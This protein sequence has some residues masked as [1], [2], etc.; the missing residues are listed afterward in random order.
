METVVLSSDIARLVLDYLKSQNLKRATHTFC[1]TSPY[2]KQEFSAFKH[3]LQT[4]SFFPELEEIICEYVKISRKVDLELPKL[5]N[6]VRFEFQ[7]LK[8]SEKVAVLLERTAD[9]HQEIASVKNASSN[10]QTSAGS[11]KQT[12]NS[13]NS[14]KEN[15]G[16][17]KKRKRPHDLN[18]SHNNDISGDTKTKDSP[19]YRT[20]HWSKKRRILEPYCFLSAKALQRHRLRYNICLSPCAMGRRVDLKSHDDRD[21]GDDDDE[22]DEDED[23]EWSNSCSEITTETEAGDTEDTECDPA[24][25]NGKELFN[26]EKPSKESTPRNKTQEE[27][28]RTPILPEISQAILDNPEFQ[29]KLVENINQALNSSATKLPPSN[30]DVKATEDPASQITNNQTTSTQDQSAISSTQLLD[31]MIKN[32]LEA[33][34]KDPSFD[35][36]IHDVLEASNKPIVQSAA[37]QCNIGAPTADACVSA[38]VGD[39]N[40]PLYTSTEPPPLVPTRP[41]PAMIDQTLTEQHQLPQAVN[42]SPIDIPPRTPLII[43]NAV[44]AAN[45]SNMTTT[46][47]S[48]AQDPPSLTANNSFGSLIDPNFSISKLIVLNSNDSAQK[49]HPEVSIGNITAENIINQLTTSS[50]GVTENVSGSGVVTD[51][52]GDDQVFFDSSTGQLTFPL[53]LTNDGLLANLPFLINNEVV[54]QQLQTNNIAN[55]DASRIEIPLSEPIVVSADQFP[56]NSVIIGSI[57]K[58]NQQ[59]ENPT[60]QQHTVEKPINVEQ[61]TCSTEP[62]G[63]LDTRLSEKATPST[64]GIVNTKA[65]RSLSTPRKRASHV[66]TLT[67]SPRAKNA[68]EGINPPT[69]QANSNEEHAKGGNS[70]KPIIKNVEILK[71]TT[72]NDTTSASVNE[73]TGNIPPL[74]VAEECSNQTVINKQVSAA[75]TANDTD[76]SNTNLSDLSKSQNSITSVENTPKRKQQRK[77]AV[78]SCKRQLSKSQTEEDLQVEKAEKENEKKIPPQGTEEYEK[79]MLEEWNRIKNSSNTD[80]DV[81]L[82]ELNSKMTVLKPVKKVNTKKRVRRKKP[83]AIKR[84]EK[85]MAE[86]AEELEMSKE[87]VNESQESVNDSQ[88]AQKSTNVDGTKGLESKEEPSYNLE[89]VEKQNV[90]NLG[91]KKKSKEFSIQIS[92]PYKVDETTIAVAEVSS[93]QNK[94]KAEDQ[95]SK[96]EETAQTNPIIP[97]ESHTESKTQPKEFSQEKAKSPV[98]VFH[99]PSGQAPHTH[100]HQPHHSDPP[101]PHINEAL[102]REKRTSNIALLLETPYKDPNVSNLS[103]AFMPPTPGIFAPSLETPAGKNRNPHDDMQASTSFLFGSLT[104][105]ELDTPML[106]ALTPGFR[107]TPFGIKDAATPRSVTGTEYSSGGGSYYK[108][109]ESEDLDRN[110]DKILRDSAQKNQ[111]QEQNEETDR[112]E[113]DEE[114][115]EIKSPKRNPPETDEEHA[116]HAVEVEIPV[117]TLKVEPIVLKR[118][119]SF[120]TEAVDSV[121][122]AKID[123][124]YTLVSGLPEISAAED[125]ESSSS[126]SSSSSSGSSSSSSSSSSSDSNSSTK[127]KTVV[128]IKSTKT[129]LDLDNLSEISSTEDEE[130]KKIV[131]EKDENSQLVNIDGEVRYPV[132][133]WLTPIKENIATDNSTILPMPA[134]VTTATSTI[135]V[136]LPLKSAEKRNRQ[137][138]ELELKRERMKEKLK[139]DATLVGATERVASTATTAPNISAALA[140][141]RLM[142]AMRDHGKK[143]ACFEIPPQMS[144]QV[145]TDEKRSIDVLTALHLSAKKQLPKTP[146]SNKPK[147]KSKIEHPPTP[148]DPNTS[149]TPE[150]KENP[151]MNISSASGKGSQ[152]K[153]LPIEARP[154]A[155]T[156]RKTNKKI[157]RTPLAFKTIQSP[158]KINSHSTTTTLAELANKSKDNLLSPAIATVRV[159]PRLVKPRKTT[160]TK[161]SPESK[162]KASPKTT[163]AKTA[164]AA[165]APK[166]KATRATNKKKAATSTKASKKKMDLDDRR[167]GMLDERVIKED[168][169]KLEVPPPP[170]HPKLNIKPKIPFKP[171]KTSGKTKNN[172]NNN[173]LAEDVVAHEKEHQTVTPVQNDEALQMEQEAA[174]KSIQTEITNLPLEPAAEAAVNDPIS[175]DDATYDCEIV[176]YDESDSKHFIHCTYQGSDEPPPTPVKIHDLSNYKMVVSLDGVEE[177]VWRISEGITLY[178]SQPAQGKIRTVPK[179]R[180]VRVTHIADD[181][182]SGGPSVVN[183]KIAAVSLKAFTSAATPG[184]TSTPVIQ[185]GAA[186]SRT[187]AT[188]KKDEGTK[189]TTANNSEKQSPH[190]EGEEEGCNV[191]QKIHI[192]DIE[193]ILS[194]LHGT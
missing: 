44:A 57:K 137:I 110:I 148:E 20:S 133:S 12:S 138:K 185:G 48:S 159:S 135:K 18:H 108:P 25:S 171:A 92:T 152:R 140:A 145:I 19:S 61:L 116:A 187:E 37:V 141:T 117:E 174:I 132:R 28:I 24:C 2:L 84:K 124:H 103:T 68:N 154:V 127:S 156:I 182:Q 146:E 129:L 157:V 7:R 98:S 53:Y 121:E 172:N 186:I 105:S 144:P 70:E 13:I 193:S 47:A 3:G 173:E 194:H 52:N 180:K 77:T 118:V 93:A 160:K 122:T 153:C 67:F 40:K 136:T 158:G 166:P 41:Q 79:Y 78:R 120:G 49:Q 99:A 6:D 115:G 27:K 91:Q 192:E 81:R 183:T 87:M 176:T 29:Q 114:E 102:E 179:K 11:G 178:T 30:S 5:S 36:V 45:A 60:V 9:N 71:G 107:F 32:I 69:S 168:E 8:L 125:E 73:S 134:P 72:A 150:N 167:E 46:M 104:K 31:Q 66:R 22:E 155:K 43:R 191:N 184:A 96:A 188:S 175:E 74:F 86:E 131:T 119:K 126:S 35:A 23:D 26:G 14:D 42:I 90:D 75:I 63:S 190:K 113:D 38:A 16:N 51:T 15:N 161:N 4:H 100:H 101:P 21:G 142:H 143:P 58:A 149:R 112:T 83:A 123:P 151:R 54:T 65:Y 82:R 106:S 33:T 128:E 189:T 59:L 89:S 34:E 177:H 170:I 165:A 39:F 130:W 55:M 17:G 181:K 1:K 97:K 95:K 163:K 85:E 109:D 169:T 64:S 162:T 56:R 80:L 10:L 50:G 147:N 164:A 62:P 94:A 88:S 139:K 111:R 76:K